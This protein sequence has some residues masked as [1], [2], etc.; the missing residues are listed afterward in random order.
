ML[1]TQFHQFEPH[2]V[3]AMVFIAESHFSI[4]TWPE[5]GYAACDLLTC[6]TMFP[7]RAIEHVRV[8]LC[9]TRV[10]TSI[11]SRGIPA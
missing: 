6:G 7:D 3:S 2:G 10:E 11:L 8:A 9:A 5:D 4:H 1:G